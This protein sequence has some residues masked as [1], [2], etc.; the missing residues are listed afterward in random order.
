MLTAMNIGYLVSVVRAMR[1]SLEREEVE[2][3][4]EEAEY[5][6]SIATSLEEA[7]AGIKSWAAGKAS[8]AI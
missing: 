3:V 1:G 5:R 2:N 7:A 6:L 8:L 4:M